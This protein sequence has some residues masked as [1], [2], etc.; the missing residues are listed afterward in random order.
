MIMRENY[1]KNVKDALRETFEEN[2]LQ[3]DESLLDLYTLL[4]LTK[5]LKVTEKDVHEAWAIYTNQV[6]P[7]HKSLIPFEDLT[8]P[9]QDLD[10]P[11]SEAIK[12]TF[13][14]L[15][16]DNILED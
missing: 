15:I 13:I 14:K 16:P 7:R 11:Y 12:N 8:K 10:T 6:N 9:V 5:G 1:I 4:L 2:D 3:V